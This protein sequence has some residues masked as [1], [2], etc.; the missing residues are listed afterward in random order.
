MQ[1][2]KLNVKYID[3]VF[4]FES[5][6]FITTDGTDLDNVFDTIK[7]Q[8]T[9]DVEKFMKNGSGWTILNL[10]RFDISVFEYNP[11]SGS[12][13]INFQ[14]IKVKFKGKEMDLDKIL[15]G[16]KAIIN[17]QNNDNECFKWSIV[18]AL[19]E[20][21]CKDW[22]KFKNCGTSSRNH[23]SSFFVQR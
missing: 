22:V 3:D 8:I 20:N 2:M 10:E 7:K 16:R 17:M 5:K 14:D 4:P 11:F 23:P 21:F 6:I 18:R 19:R 15:S 12:T 9:E 1:E 13:H